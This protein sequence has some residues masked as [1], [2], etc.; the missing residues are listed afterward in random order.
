MDWFKKAFEDAKK[1]FHTQEITLV[2]EAEGKLYHGTYV[3]GEKT[4]NK[5]IACNVQ[6]SG[7]EQFYKEYGYYIEVQYTAFC[8]VDT[9]I[10]EGATVLYEGVEY[11]IKKLV[12]WHS[13][14]IL[15]L[16]AVDNG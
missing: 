13:Y 7:R 11:T 6:P 1:F 3:E 8:D 12:D 9:D 15:Y 5:V 2:S 16:G 14:Y 4:P 10:K